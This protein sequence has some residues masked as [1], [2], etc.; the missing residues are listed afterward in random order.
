[1]AL[2]SQGPKQPNQTPSGDP[3]DPAGLNNLRNQTP[4]LDCLSRSEK[5]AVEIWLMAQLANLLG[6]G[7]F[8]NINTLM[9]ASACLKCEPDFALDSMEVGI[10]LT[11]Y[12]AVSHLTPSI[13]TLRANIKCL[14]CADQKAL[15]AAYV[16]LLA[17]IANS[18]I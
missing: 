11:A 2:I 3:G 5:N 15:R 16:F 14:A 6:Q 13:A 4:C 1:M 8:T 10:W 12:E 7:D 17:K 9:S 18:Q